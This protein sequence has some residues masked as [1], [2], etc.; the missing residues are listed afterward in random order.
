MSK[1]ER[2]S[3]SCSSLK[4]SSWFLFRDVGL[5]DTDVSN[6]WVEFAGETSTFLMFLKS[7]TC[8]HD[9]KKE[10]LQQNPRAFR[11]FALTTCLW[12]VRESPI[13]PGNFYF[14]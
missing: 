1:G 7:P 8:F 3:F 5:E 12:E 10:V 13:S 6:V 4:F 9:G 11:N 2:K 14:N